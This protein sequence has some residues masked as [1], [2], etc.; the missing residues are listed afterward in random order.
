MK[1]RRIEIAAAAAGFI[2]LLLVWYLVDALW[3]KGW[4]M[5]VIHFFA[6]FGAALVTLAAS[7]IVVVIVTRYRRILE[8]KNQQLE[9]LANIGGTVAGLAHYQKNL[10]NGLRGGLYIADGAMER[11][12]VERIREGW[13]MLNNTVLRIE[14]LTM[15]MLYYVKQRSINREPTDI[16]QL[17]EEVIGL[18][19][20]TAAGR[21]VELRVQLDSGMSLQPLDR[22]AIYRSLLNLVSNA[23]DACTETG[24]GGLV[25]L[26][27]RVTP[28]E[29][30]VTVEDDGI[31]M[32]DEILSHLFVQFYSTKGG[33]GTGL[34]LVVVKEIIEQHGASLEVE[35]EPGHG[36]AFH[37]HFP[38]APVTS[39]NRVPVSSTKANGERDVGQ[40]AHTHSRGP[41]RNEPLHVTD[42]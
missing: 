15:D 17:I 13:N 7:L 41:R 3:A 24:A 22:T 33:K 38:K 18:M 1:E 6:I 29:M 32:T 4:S 9:R 28:N 25:T 39:H 14:R 11:G 26:K 40:K 2:G 8:G 35:S 19:R 42:S 5:D 12:D 30:V 23:I 31:G 16:N 20:E 27:S 34:G 10:L 37:L 21:Q 36:S